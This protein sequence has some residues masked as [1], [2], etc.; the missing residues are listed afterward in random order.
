MFKVP[1]LLDDFLA[2]FKLNI[3]GNYTDIDN[4]VALFKMGIYW[5][6]SGL[7]L[8]LICR[9]I[10]IGMVGLGYTFP[11]GIE[12][13]KLKYREPFRS[14]VGRIP[15]YQDIVIRLE[16]VSSSL[17]SISF[18][19]FMSLIGGYIYFFVLLVIPVSIAL[20]Y[21]EIE[22]NGFLFD[23]WIYL[24]LSVG[25]IALIDFLSLGYFRRFRWISRLYWPI[26][27]LISAL[28]LSR[29][30][31]PI[32][33]GLVTNFN[34]PGIVIR[35]LGRDERPAK[36]LRFVPYSFDPFSSFHS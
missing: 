27:R 17:F 4:L 9:G 22:W 21:F 7:I 30:Y 19:L 16:K 34:K 32:Y 1:D 26:H 14:K 5:L 29:F 24:V 33:Y 15:A 36:I 25:V 8:H 20:I 6:I 13:D 23:A 3:H 2:F 35:I 10:W 12:L 18:M 31:R 28:T 11:H